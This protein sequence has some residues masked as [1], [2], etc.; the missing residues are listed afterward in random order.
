M[1]DRIDICEKH[2]IIR[3]ALKKFAC[4]V[5]GRAPKTAKDYTEIYGTLSSSF[6]GK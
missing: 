2:L 5:L 6:Y 1:K 3:E 4:E